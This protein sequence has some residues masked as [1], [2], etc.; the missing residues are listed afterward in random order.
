MRS[1]LWGLEKTE[2]FT[3]PLFRPGC[4]WQSDPWY[5]ECFCAS[6]WSRGNH[7]TLKK[8]KVSLVYSLGGR[9]LRIVILSWLSNNFL[10]WCNTK[11]IIATELG[12]IKYSL[13]QKLSKNANYQC[14]FS[15]IFD[16]D[17]AVTHHSIQWKSRPWSTGLDLYAQLVDVSLQVGR[18]DLQENGMSLLKKS[19][20]TYTYF[21]MSDIPFFSITMVRS[22]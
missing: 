18:P 15:A 3:R 5:H 2:L 19:K 10:T 11:F 16:F 7:S 21:F 4:H 14:I 22:R 13:G 1:S 12:R 9:L 6:L 17:A 8:E 20:S